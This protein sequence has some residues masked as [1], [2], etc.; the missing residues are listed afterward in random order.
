MHTEPLE[1]QVQ[2]LERLDLQGL[3][4]AWRGRY[5][6]PPAL[7][8]QELLRLMLAWRIQAEAFGGLD[9]T[10]RR[11][12]RAKASL[13]A[14]GLS[15]GV[16]A[17]LRREWQGRSVEVEVAQDGFVWEGRLYRSLSA[18]ATAIAGVKWNGPRFFG[19]RGAC[20]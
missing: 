4:E 12:L 17:K 16:G 20:A 1:A 18:V 8:S 5:G 11:R 10:L 6:A 19:L 14:E 3:R 2:A 7:R 9:A 15:L 13:P